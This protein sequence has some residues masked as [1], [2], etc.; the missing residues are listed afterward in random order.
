MGMALAVRDNDGIQNNMPKF[1]EHNGQGFWQLQQN[2]ARKT[3]S[4]G[5]VL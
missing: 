2:G 4:P 3:I 1:K 5:C